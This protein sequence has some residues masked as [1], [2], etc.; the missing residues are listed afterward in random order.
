MT[1]RKSSLMCYCLIFLNSHQSYLVQEGSQHFW[2]MGSTLCTL[3]VYD[4]LYVALFIFA[5]I[6]IFIKKQLQ[7]ETLQL[8]ENL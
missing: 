4:C 6:L 8:D 1:Y 3:I 2:G 5:D 7:F